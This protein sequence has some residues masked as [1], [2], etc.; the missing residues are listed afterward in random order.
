MRT[1]QAI[2][3]GLII[4]LM[5]GV[6][7]QQL[8]LAGDVKEHTA[9]I[10]QLEKDRDAD[11]LAF[12]RKIVEVTDLVKEVIVSN[13]ELIQVMRMQSELLRQYRPN[14]GGGQ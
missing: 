2:V 9:K 1:A 5:A 13:R 14:S 7:L 6:G 11:R 10:S 4:G 12:D 3:V 8:T